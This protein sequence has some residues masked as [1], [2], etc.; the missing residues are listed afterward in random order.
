MKL[1]CAV[2]LKLLTY[3]EPKTQVVIEAGPSEPQVVVDLSSQGSTSEI[4]HN[5]NVLRATKKL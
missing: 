1:Y 3:G 2:Y 4:V 5:L